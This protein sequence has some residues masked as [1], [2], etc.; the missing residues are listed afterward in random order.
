[1]AEELLGMLREEPRAIEHEPPKRLITWPKADRQ[2]GEPPRQSDI[3]SVM[4]VED[5]GPVDGDDA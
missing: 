3:P 4:A 5:T 1:M 2:P